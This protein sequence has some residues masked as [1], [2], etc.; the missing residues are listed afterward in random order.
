MKVTGPSKDLLRVTLGFQ[1]VPR[2]LTTPTLP[3][4]NPPN[5][6]AKP[7][8]SLRQAVS[9]KPWGCFHQSV[10]LFLRNDWEFPDHKNSFWSHPL[11]S[12]TSQNLW[13]PS[14]NVF[15]LPRC[16]GIYF[17]WFWESKSLP[18]SIQNLSKI[19]PK[20]DVVFNIVLGL[21]FDWFP[22]PPNL[23]NGALAAAWC[24]FS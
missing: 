11:D 15:G 3:L 22:E 5:G 19:K 13:R 9:T 24:T 6:D 7:Q 17:Y 1:E 14:K 10:G 16:F 12:Q 23:Q 2:T 8:R 4:L 20:I 21:I 18:E